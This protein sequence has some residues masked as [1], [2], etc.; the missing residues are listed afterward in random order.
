MDKS[1][2]QLFAEFIKRVETIG[3]LPTDAK[4]IDGVIRCRRKYKI[5][6]P[7]AIIAATALR[8]NAALLRT[9]N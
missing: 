6:I 8:E 7:D 4:L 5:K 2:E 9:V 3:L 1:D